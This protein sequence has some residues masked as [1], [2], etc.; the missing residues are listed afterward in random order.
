[1]VS[2]SRSSARR[3]QTEPLAALAAV[4]VVGLAL[5]LYADAIAAARPPSSDPGTA[6]ATLQRVQ[7]HVSDGGVALPDRVPAATALAPHGHTANVTLATGNR[8]WTAGP[9]PPADA[10]SARRST[11]VRIDQ[12]SARPGTLRVVVWS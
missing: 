11:A 8:R 6:A 4:L 5:G 1:M 7:D 2:V 12:W 3:G 9:S 10:P